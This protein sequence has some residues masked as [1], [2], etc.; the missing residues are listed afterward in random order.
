MKDMLFIGKTEEINFT[1]LVG[2][3]MLLKCIQKVS[4]LMMD[5]V[6]YI[7]IELDVIRL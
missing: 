3:K 1:N 4:A 2:M 6:F 7:Q 5:I